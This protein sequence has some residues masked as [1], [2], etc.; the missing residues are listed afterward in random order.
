MYSPMRRWTQGARKGS[1]ID[2]AEFSR[3]LRI[4]IYIRDCLKAPPASIS[5][6]YSALRDEAVEW[7]QVDRKNPEQVFRRAVAISELYCEP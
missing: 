4:Y 1:K 5:K 7:V 2:R 3:V 6:S